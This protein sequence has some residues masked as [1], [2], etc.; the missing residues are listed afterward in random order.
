MR[1]RI[2][3]GDEGIEAE[4]AQRLLAYRSERAKLTLP[5]PNDPEYMSP[6]T[7]EAPP[8]LLQEFRGRRRSRSTAL[9]SAG[10]AAQTGIA[11]RSA[12][13]HRSQE[14]LPFDL[15]HPDLHGVAGHQL[16]ESVE[17]LG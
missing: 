14:P 3:D 12:R 4:I 6:T 5:V 17:R 16:V 7:T 2:F 15:R 10:V 8:R 1:F 13:A 11:C 9:L